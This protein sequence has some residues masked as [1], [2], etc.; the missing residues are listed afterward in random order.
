[1][2][3]MALLPLS[4]FAQDGGT[5]QGLAP[6]LLMII[7]V[8]VGL[9]LIVTYSLWRVSIHLKKFMKGEF[10]TEEQK[11]YDRRSV[12]EKIFQLKPVGTD[13]DV[14][15]GH[16]YDGIRELDNPPPPWFMFLFYGTIAFAVIYFIGFFITDDIPTQQEEYI[17]EVEQEEARL[18]AMTAS[19]DAEGGDAVAAVDEA[20]LMLLTDAAALSAGESIY[21]KNCKVCHAD[22]GRGSVGPNLTDEFWIHGGGVIEVYKTIKDG[23]ITK[24]MQSWDGILT[25]EEMLQVTSYILKLDKIGPPDGL[26]PQGEE[27]TAP[28]EEEPSE[29]ADSSEAEEVVEEPVSEA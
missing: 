17:A 19:T 14:M 5:S 10:E 27:W 16:A 7:Y 28:V 11:M 21:K 22:G 18:A 15:M 6:E 25:P 13:K 23:V 9:L 24:G 3:I 4:T 29:A 12:W 1:M 26:E 20:S 8:I 2:T